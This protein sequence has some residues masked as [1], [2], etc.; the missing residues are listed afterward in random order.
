[1]WFGEYWIIL[2]IWRDIICNFHLFDYAPILAN[3][4]YIVN[5]IILSEKYIIHSC[6]D[7]S[8]SKYPG[9]F[10]YLFTLR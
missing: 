4:L 10:T 8:H 9:L 2:F 6:Q 1:M 3:M 5:I 7:M